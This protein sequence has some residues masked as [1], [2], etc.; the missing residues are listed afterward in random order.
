MEETYHLIVNQMRQ[1]TRPW[2]VNHLEQETHI[3]KSESK[4]KKEPQI[5]RVNHKF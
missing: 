2:Q 3:E 5:E 1:E 4:T